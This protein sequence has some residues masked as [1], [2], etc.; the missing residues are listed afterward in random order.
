M[1]KLPPPSGFESRLSEL[2]ARLDS[3]GLRALDPKTLQLILAA[4]AVADSDDDASLHG[5]AARRAGASWAEIE[6]LGLLVEQAGGLKATGKASEFVRAVQ[7][8]ERQA[9]VDGAVAA[10]G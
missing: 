8:I 2:R 6:A 4:L 9:H 7:A 1:V 5:L 3:P 10:Y